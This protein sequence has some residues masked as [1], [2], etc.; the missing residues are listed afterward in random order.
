MTTTREKERDALEKW[1]KSADGS[2]GL[3]FRAYG[4]SWFESLAETLKVRGRAP[5][6]DVIEVET[7]MSFAKIIWKDK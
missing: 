2:L 6:Q 7:P 5:R 4:N 1:H 3:L